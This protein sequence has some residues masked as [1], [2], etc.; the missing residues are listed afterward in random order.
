MAKRGRKNAFD[1]LIKPRYSEICDWARNGAT[2]KQ[3]AHNLGISRQTL[4]KYKQEKPEFLDILKNSR[5]ALVLELRGALVKKALGYKF[6]EI[7]KYTKIE[8]GKS[9]QYVEETTKESAPDVAAINLC[10][11]NYDSD[12]WANDPQLLK[13]KREEL[14]LKRELADNNW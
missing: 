11:K 14:A 3:I 7:K 5:Q 4:N 2:E 8:D 12:E 6:T 10:L 13:L 9:V 1:L